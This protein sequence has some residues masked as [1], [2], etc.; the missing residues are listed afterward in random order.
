LVRELIDNA[1]VIPAGQ[2]PVAVI[3]V[4]LG[5]SADTV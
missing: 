3:D 5:G 2:R 1:V 4:I